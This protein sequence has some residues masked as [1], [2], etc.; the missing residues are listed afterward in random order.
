L[1]TRLG[2]AAFFDKRERDVAAGIAEPVDPDEGLPEAMI[3]E[4]EGE[5]A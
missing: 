4:Q 1:K 2:R 3:E 5:P